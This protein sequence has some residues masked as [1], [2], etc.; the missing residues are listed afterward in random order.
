MMVI[1][2][3]KNGVGDVPSVKANHKVQAV[4]FAAANL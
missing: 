2:C 4:V 1:E 3:G